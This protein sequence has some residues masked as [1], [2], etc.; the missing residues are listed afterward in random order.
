MYAVPHKCREVVMA[1]KKTPKGKFYSQDKVNTIL[2]AGGR[3][4]KVSK[5]KRKM[6]CWKVDLETLLIAALRLAA[7]GKKEMRFFVTEDVPGKS[8]GNVVDPTNHMLFVETKSGCLEQFPPAEM[9]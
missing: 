1:A 7:K 6:N 3:K 9:P 4:L 2:K 5:N 8:A